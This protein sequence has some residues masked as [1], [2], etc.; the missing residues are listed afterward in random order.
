MEKKIL[1]LEQKLQSQVSNPLSFWM[2]SNV[3][4]TEQ[5]IQNSSLNYLDSKFGS[6]WMSAN[7]ATILVL[8]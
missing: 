3:G 8:F 7:Y 4:Q 5:E 1:E 2:H 6:H